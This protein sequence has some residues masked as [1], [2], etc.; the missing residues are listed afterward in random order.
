[1]TKRRLMRGNTRGSGAD[2]ALSESRVESIRRAVEQMLVA[3]ELQPGQ[4]LTELALAS[5]LGVGRGH[6]RETIRA[7]E[8]D[9]LVSTRLNHG[10][11]VSV[12]DL[13]AALEIYDTNA[14]LFG[15]AAHQLSGKATSDQLLEL[16]TLIE[17][18]TE[19]TSGSDQSSYFELNLRFHQRIFDF[20]GNRHASR[21]YGAA[22]KR[23]WLL[24][25]RTF[26]SAVNMQASNDEHAAIF[27]AIIRKQPDIARRRAE[28]HGLNG[29]KRFLL[30]NTESEKILQKAA[31]QDMASPPPSLRPA[32]RP[33]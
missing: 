25:R 4:R 6:V 2:L 30:A 19:A 9:G 13:D 20:A 1:M 17:Q 27:D 32:R 24:R 22:A 21:I 31:R 12:V 7:L 5:S 18:M 29:R 28:D 23:L 26:G 3:G 10:A 33:R 11:Y 8:H 15:Y 14:I 16:A